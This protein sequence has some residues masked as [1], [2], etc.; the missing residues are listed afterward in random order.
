M[1]LH[2]KEI[3]QVQCQTHAPVP[4]RPAPNPAQG[5]PKA[6]C[7]HSHHQA[8]AK[9]PPP[10]RHAE[11]QGHTTP[12]MQPHSQPRSTTETMPAANTAKHRGRP[13]QTPER[14]LIL[15]F[16]VAA[17]HAQTASATTTGHAQR[18]RAMREKARQRHGSKKLRTKRLKQPLHLPRHQ[19]E[20]SH[21]TRAKHPHS[22][23]SF[24]LTI[25]H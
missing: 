24:F 23:H 22:T 2:W 11:C 17:T 13:T 16:R 1:R 25:E 6:S 20:R 7:P 3:C 8:A 10:P 21:G 19:P 18:S 14:K 9:H 5:S 12:T 4:I 15:R